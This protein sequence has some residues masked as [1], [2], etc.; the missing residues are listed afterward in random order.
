MVL[1]IAEKP[2][3][4]KAI[5]N[6]IG[7]GKHNDGYY[8]GN[9][10]IVSWCVG[11]LVGLA[12]PESYDE[13]YKKW[14]L[15]DL[16]IL[17]RD[18]KYTVSKNT[19]KQFDTLK[20]LMNDKAIDSVVNACDAG[21][22]GESIFRLVYNKANCKKPIK[23]LWISSMEDSAIKEGFKKLQD[24]KNYENLFKAAE[25]R[26]KADWLIGMNISRLYTIKKGEFGKTA[27]SVGRV[28]TPTLAMIYYRDIKVKNFVPE[29]YYQVEIML[30]GFRMIS[31][32]LE[33][34]EKASSVLDIIGNEIEIDEVVKEEK[35]TKP[36]LPYDLT[37]LQRE[38]NKLYGYSAAKTL[39]LTQ[40]LY[41]KKMLTYPR[42]DSRYLTEDM[43]D[44]VLNV[45]LK[46]FNVDSKRNEIVFDSSKVSNHHAIIPTESSLN[47][48]KNSLSLE[49][50]SIY[51]LCLNK[52]YATFSHPLIEDVTKIKATIAETEFT[53]SG[54]IVKQKGFKEFTIRKKEKES[55]DD[56]AEEQNLPNIKEND[57]FIVMEKKANEKFTQP[58]KHFTEDTLLKAMEIAGSD[59]LQKGV[60]IERKG[61]GTPATRAGIIENLISKEY[62]K[63]EKKNLMATDKGKELIEIVSEAFKSPK[64]TADFEMELANIASGKAKDSEFL[65]KIENLIEE[66][67]LKER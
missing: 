60:E 48:D 44:T 62:I 11:H 52:L 25:A 53:A 38:A 23:R 10:Y 14:N 45:L 19:K 31:E 47:A 61:I 5:A 59:F 51:K 32:K 37:S 24:G 55:K 28:Q 67:I 35:L 41:E 42:T 46:G 26:A 6:V 64:T 29:K 20:K 15:Q 36:P 7:A 58:P 21:R 27:Y 3:V 9:G 65:K 30:D 33:D 2:S 12:N 17:P 4:A 34:I 40:S 49:E 39:E 43:K 66:E 63:R 18:Y 56:K 50:A 8:E 16:P 54:K 1:V 57:S 13:K 22:E